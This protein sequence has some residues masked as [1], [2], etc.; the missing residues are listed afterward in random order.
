MN[1]VKEPVLVVA[2][3]IQ[4]DFDREGRVLLVR[5][6]PNQSGAGDWEFPG[7][8][9][10]VGESAEQ[11]LVRE[12]QEELCLQIEV[13]SLVGEIDFQYPTKII[14]LRVYKA[15]TSSGDVRLSEHD[16]LK[17]CMPIEI[18]LEE[19]SAADRPFVEK[20]LHN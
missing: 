5:R 7:G 14:R 20:L 1:Q 19:L 12:I 16:D 13:G 11:A 15:V 3:V 17:W 2:A 9:V 8:K 18:K 10:E 4:R 6:G